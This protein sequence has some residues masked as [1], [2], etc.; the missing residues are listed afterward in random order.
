VI[1]A[2]RSTGD[3]VFPFALAQGSLA[4]PGFI[5]QQLLSGPAMGVRG[6]GQREQF[7]GQSIL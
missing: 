3:T 7:L 6:F 4:A 5:R 2:G 1:C